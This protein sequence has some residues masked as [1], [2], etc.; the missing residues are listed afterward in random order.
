M[1]WCLVILL[2]VSLVRPA[3]G[4]NEEAALDQWAR[5]YLR[6]QTGNQLRDAGAPQL[7]LT[8]FVEA[9]GLFEKLAVEYPG[10]ETDVVQYRIRALRRE[11]AGI[12]EALS[13]DDARLSDRFAAFLA[14]VEQAD[15]ERYSGDRKKALE[16][17]RTA[18]GELDGIVAADPGTLAPAVER[19]R[20]RLTD[21]I[22]WLD[23]LLNRSP[24][25]AGRMR[26]SPL[27]MLGTTEF[28]RREDLPSSPGMVASAKSLF[29]GR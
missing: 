12:E 19:H 20:V 27:R 11:I 22:D 10:Y 3:S 1:K 16:T 2:S 26:A 28:I 8:G 24:A 14:Q 9:L 25:P 4:F 18:L 21:S 15:E 6:L 17:M 23:R 29:P 5:A 13:E 7:A